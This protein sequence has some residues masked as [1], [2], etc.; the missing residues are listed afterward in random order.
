MQIIAQPA[1]PACTRSSACTG[2]GRCN[3]AARLAAC[4]A[5]R[6][7]A[8]RSARSCWLGLPMRTSSRRRCSATRA[9]AGAETTVPRW[10]RSG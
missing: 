9:M 1:A 6:L 10:A 8:G 5:M 4:N 3:A 7:A 2:G